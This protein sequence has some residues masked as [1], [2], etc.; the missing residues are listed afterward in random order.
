MK[1]MKVFLV[2]YFGRNQRMTISST[3]EG[4][5][6]EGILIHCRWC[7]DYYKLWRKESGNVIKI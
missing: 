4:M 2:N 3:V 5:E 6:K 7:N 1:T